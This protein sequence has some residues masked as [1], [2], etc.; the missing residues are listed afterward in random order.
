MK[1]QILI[2]LDRLSDQVGETIT[3]YHWRELQSIILVLR[4]LW[5][6]SDAQW[7]DLLERTEDIPQR[8]EG[9]IVKKFDQLPLNFEE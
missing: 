4:E 1:E 3:E 7:L 5:G 2:S 9:K 8:K 6:I